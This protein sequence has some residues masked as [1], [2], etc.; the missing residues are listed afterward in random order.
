M[1]KDYSKYLAYHLIY[2]L[3]VVCVVSIIGN[4]IVLEGAAYSIQHILLIYAVLAF[5]HIFLSFQSKVP[6]IA[7]FALLLADS[8]A[9]MVLARTSGSSQS[10]FLVLFPLLTLADSIIFRPY[11]AL[12]LLAATIV[13]QFFAIGFGLA[14]VGN[15]LATSTISVLG[16]FL[17]KAL[18]QSDT[19]LKISEVARRRLENLQKAI[20]ANIPSGLLS[21][22]SQGRVIQMNQVGLRILGYKEQ[23]ILMKSINEI[24]PGIDGEIARLNTLHPSIE[25]MDIEHRHDRSSLKFYKKDGQ[26]LELGYTV[27]RLS[28][29]GDKSVLGSL[30]VFQDLTQIIQMEENLRLSQKLA[31]VGKL[32]AGIAHEIRNPLAGISGSAQLLA[33]LESLGDED[34]KLL[35]IIQ[36]ESA[37]L[38]SLITEFLEYVRPQKPKLEKVNLKLVAERVVESLRVN[39]KWNELKCQIQVIE[40]ENVSYMMVY[41]DE[42]KIIQALF[43]LALNGGQAKASQVVIDLSQK[44]TLLIRDNGIGIESANQARLFEPFF[45]T[46]EGGTGLGLATS[47]RSLEAMGARIRVES[48]LPNFVPQGGGTMFII[49]FRET[50]NQ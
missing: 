23:Q 6:E 38:D 29:P 8:V 50:D 15:V 47:Y 26:S 45:T 34:K 10:P 7:L 39:A 43:N 22:D 4:T 21:V 2:L 37:R 1:Q 32:A 49:S 24:L 36:K 30:V 31:A 5:G 19:A 9:V 12:I 11:F 40:P 18:Y 16:L 17:E 46:K 25:G 33:T 41:G 3:I 13:F 28:D 27:A 14:F 42:N 48:P 20:L 44:A 35:A